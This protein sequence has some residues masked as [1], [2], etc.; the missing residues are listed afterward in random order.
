MEI[1]INFFW[2]ILA[3]CGF[4]RSSMVTAAMA[5]MLVEAVLKEKPVKEEIR[6]CT[7]RPL[8][9]NAFHTWTVSGIP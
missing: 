5:L 1:R 7:F 8:F 6:S 2:D 9:I 3:R 4:S